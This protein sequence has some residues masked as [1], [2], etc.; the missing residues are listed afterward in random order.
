MAFQ[1]RQAE[2][3]NRKKLN[4][5]SIEKNSSGEITS[6]TVDIFRDEGKVINEGTALTAE[7]LNS[8]IAAA[9]AN[10]VSTM[11]PTAWTQSVYDCSTKV[12]TTEF[13]WNVLVALNHTKLKN[14]NTG[15][16]SGNGS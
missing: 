1:N 12:A 14:P 2:F 11:G 13:V 9:V 15:G 7:N 16:G 6:L 5:L 4:V 3:L 10:V 8:E